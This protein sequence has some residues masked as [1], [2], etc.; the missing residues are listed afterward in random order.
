MIKWLEKMLDRKRDSE[1]RKY[2]DWV[3]SIKKKNHERND[4]NT[5]EWSDKNAEEWICTGNKNENKNTEEWKGKNAE[6]WICTVR[7]LAA[8]GWSGKMTLGELA[9]LCGT[10]RNK[11]EKVAMRRVK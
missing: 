6:E 11:D 4:K 2:L 10:A 5:E 3:D 1:H 9:D 7:V 8:P